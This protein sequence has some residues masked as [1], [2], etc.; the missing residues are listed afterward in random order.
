LADSPMIPYASACEQ[1]VS[2]LGVTHQEAS[3][4]LENAAKAGVV[5][6]SDSVAVIGAMPLGSPLWSAAHAW[7]AVEDLDRLIAGLGGAVPTVAKKAGRKPDWP[8][9]ALAF[10]AGHWAQQNP[11]RSG[12]CAAVA[13]F[14]VEEAKRLTGREPTLKH[15]E[16][17]VSEWWRILEEN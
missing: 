15:C 7:Y 6:A 5:Q 13:A 16:A 10:A 14:V 17:K 12:K 2:A 4:T 8:W 3:H 9:E 11:E 1:L